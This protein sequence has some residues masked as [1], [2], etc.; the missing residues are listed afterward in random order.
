MQSKRFVAPIGYAIYISIIFLIM[1]EN[2]DKITAP[3]DL[4]N[5]FRI[6]SAATM[7]M[8][9]VVNAIILGFLW[10]K[11]QPHTTRQQEIS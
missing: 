8:Y 9:W 11:F 7:T 6:V 10:Q 3:I 5:G 2:P 4:V 1:P